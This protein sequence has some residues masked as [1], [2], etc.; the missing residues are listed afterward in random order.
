MASTRMISAGTMA[1]LF[2]RATRT[3]ISSMAAWKSATG[4]NEIVCV[5]YSGTAAN[6]ARSS[7][8][9]SCALSLI[10][11]PDGEDDAA[12]VEER[13]EGLVDWLEEREGAEDRPRR[14]AA[15]RAQLGAREGDDDLEAAAQGLVDERRGLADHAL[16][17]VV[18]RGARTVRIDDDVR[19]EE[20]R[21]GE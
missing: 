13:R 8:S 1:G 11:P 2:P 14:V 3:T 10:G 16:E 7:A 19:S 17:V 20:R 4:A 15:A 12:A 21:V 6:M 5:T 9:T 18:G